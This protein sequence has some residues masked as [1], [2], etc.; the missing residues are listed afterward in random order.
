[1]FLSLADLL[2]AVKNSLS[3][4]FFSQYIPNV[5]IE[6]NINVILVNSMHFNSRIFVII[7]KKNQGYI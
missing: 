4:M 5:V 1:M 7:I 6:A 2:I 3:G